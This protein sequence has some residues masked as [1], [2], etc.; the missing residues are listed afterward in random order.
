M[1]G[2]GRLVNGSLLLNLEG[3]VR[4]R[5]QH[6]SINNRVEVDPDTVESLTFLGRDI[7]DLVLDVLV[8]VQEAVPVIAT[9]KDIWP[10]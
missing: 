6:Q 9:N 2:E 7:L 1:H 5:W 8:D 4:L 10:W 3:M